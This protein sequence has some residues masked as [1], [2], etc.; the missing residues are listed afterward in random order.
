MS[1]QPAGLD[2][3]S[4]AAEPTLEPAWL[5]LRLLLADE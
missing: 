5:T 1:S 2:Q 3:L 4:Y